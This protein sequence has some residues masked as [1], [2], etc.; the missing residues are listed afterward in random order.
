M[1][2]LFW[3][4]WWA[5]LLLVLGLLA[6][7][8]IA[9]ACK[10]GKAEL[11]N[12]RMPASHS[13][14]TKIAVFGDTQKGLAGFAALAEIAK[15]EGVDLAI[16]TGDLVSQAD[17][18]HYDLALRWIER[19]RLGVPLVVTP[20]NHD[21]KG[22]EKLFEER[23]GR[24]QLA[25]PWGPVDIVVIDNSTGPPDEA[26]AESMIAQSNRPILLFMHVPPIEAPT[27]NYVPKPAYV[28]FLQM[29]RKYPVTHVFS[30]HAHGYS[31]VR[32]G[33]VVFVSNGVG[34][35]SD[36]WQFG[37]KA[38]LTIVEASKDAIGSREISIDPVFS[39]GA[40]VEHLAIGHVGEILLRRIWGIPALLLLMAAL[41]FS[42][43]GSRKKEGEKDEPEGRETEKVILKE[44]EEGEVKW[45][46]TPSKSSDPPDVVI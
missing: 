33:S 43:R 30:G 3:A 35:D 26:A 40:N 11:G 18:G 41:Y 1:R 23:I 44:K 32:D 36:S 9:I 13:E 31:K 22:G 6:C 7:L 27:T 45:K 28:K 37:Q 8:G 16:H 17:A 20:G 29:I 38:H 42:W 46:F 10:P 14:K 39:W 15:K 25:F 34:G 19:A 12:R 21:V 4:T 5:S 24:R 2:R